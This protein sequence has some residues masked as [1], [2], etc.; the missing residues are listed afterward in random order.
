MTTPPV[1]FRPLTRA[2]L[3]LV[4]RWLAEPQ[5]HRW[6]HDEASLE[7]VEAEYGPSVDG[8]E[9]TEVFLALADGE[10]FGLIQR[11]RIADYPEDLAELDGVVPVPPGAVS[12]D[13]LI[14]DASW[15]GRGLGAAMIAAFV[16]DSWA[17]FPDAPEVLVPVVAGNTAS[18]RSLERAGF[19]RVAEGELEPDNPR[20]PRDHYVY[21]LA[22]PA[23]PLG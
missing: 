3:P 5:V 1:T 8:S 15:R 6:W 14:G 2:D 21:R 13:Y 16:A 23:A 19:T 7:A 4:A 20:D 11:Y 9:P 10:P 17:A 18:W 12:V 22:R